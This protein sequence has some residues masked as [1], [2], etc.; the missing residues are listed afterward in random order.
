MTT[1]AYLCEPEDF[2]KYKT[3]LTVATVC[4]YIDKQTKIVD[5]LP[6]REEAAFMLTFEVVISQL[7]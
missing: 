2:K 6:F 4:V 1:K 7:D 5:F 3:L